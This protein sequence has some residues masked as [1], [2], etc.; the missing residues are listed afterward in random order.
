MMRHRSSSW[1]LCAESQRPTRFA[2]SARSAARFCPSADSGGSLPFSGSTIS[3]VRRLSGECRL[4][5]V[6]PELAEVV[7]HVGDGSGR[8]QL[9]FVG[10]RRVSRLRSLRP[11]CRTPWSRSWAAG[12]GCTWSWSRTP[13]CPAARPACAEACR[14]SPSGSLSFQRVASVPRRGPEPAT[15]RRPSVNRR[16]ASNGRVIGNLLAGW[17]WLRLDS[18]IIPGPRESSAPLRMRSVE[19]FRSRAS[20]RAPRALR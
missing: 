15:R 2:S 3:D 16:T 14:A 20:L 7:V 18:P 5:L 8:G 19:A 11:A 1:L 9:A 10:R 4:A 12:A 13:G 17:T 6:E